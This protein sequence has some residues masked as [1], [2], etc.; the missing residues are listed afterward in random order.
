MHETSYKLR[1][2]CF[3]SY[4]SGNKNNFHRGFRGSSPDIHQSRG[5][6]GGSKDNTTG[7]SKDHIITGFRGMSSSHQ[8]LFD[9]PPIATISRC[10]NI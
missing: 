9:I 1:K 7:G 8:A 4:V 2:S 5:S 6:P 3:G 10:Y